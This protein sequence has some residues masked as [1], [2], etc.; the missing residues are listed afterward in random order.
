MDEAR[1]SSVV[2][3]DMA[4]SNGLKLEHK[5]PYKMQMNFFTVRVTEH[6]NTLSRELVESPFM[7]IFKTHLNAYL[8]DLL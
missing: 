6:W 8:C 5:I 1:L 2:Y 4:R 3:S 7:E